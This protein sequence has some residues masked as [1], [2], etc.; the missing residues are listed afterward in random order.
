MKKGLVFA[1]LF[2]FLIQC[3]PLGVYASIDDV[4]KPTVSRN[5]DTQT[6]AEGA[7]N[8]HI[9]D[10]LR[11]IGA[12]KESDAVNAGKN[13]TREYA[14]AVLARAFSLSAGTG[15]KP[16]T[17]VDE[18]NV[19]IN[20][21]SALK[22][23]GAIYCVGREFEPKKEISAGEL[24]YMAIKLLGQEWTDTPEEALREAQEK[25]LF[26]GTDLPVRDG[27][28]I[29]QLYIFVCNAL[30]SPRTEYVP[31]SDGGWKTE[32]KESLLEDRNIV[33]SE[34]IITG[35]GV[36]TVYGNELRE[37]AIELDRKQFNTLKNAEYEDVGK[38]AVTFIDADDGV[39]ISYEQRN[40]EVYK[41]KEYGLEE[42]EQK[43]I[44]YSDE[45]GKTKK[46]TI[47]ENAKLIYNGTGMGTYADGYGIIADNMTLE[48]I[49]NNRDGD[50]DIVKVENPEYLI[51]E[52]VSEYSEIVSL[53]YG[54]GNINF[55]DGNNLIKLTKGGKDISFAEL[56]KRMV[57]KSLHS[58]NNAG[59]EIYII[60]VSDKKITG[61]VTEIE[62]DEDR[63]YYRVGKKQYVL[64]Q[65]YIEFLSSDSSEKKPSP[66][67]TLTFC[68]S[69]DGKI[70][71]SFAA[72]GEIYFGFLTNAFPDEENEEDIRVR[73]FEVHTDEAAIYKLADK[74]KFYDDS[75][76]I[77]GRKMKA[78]DIYPYLRNNGEKR[79]AVV[80]YNFN[81]ENEL[82]ELAF[83]KNLEGEK[84][85][86]CDYPL[87]KNYM[88]TG[89]NG[90]KTADG[91]LY[92]NVL[93]AKWYFGGNISVLY[94][95]SEPE[96]MSDNTKY[97]VGKISDY[98]TEHYF[99]NEKAYVY[100]ADKTYCGSL[101]VVEGGQA[102]GQT[103]KEECKAVMINRVY[104]GLSDDEPV[105]MVEVISPGGEPKTLCLS[106]DAEISK[107]KEI[108]DSQ[109]SGY[110]WGVDDDSLDKLKCGDI[111]QYETDS[112]GRM[113]VVR[114]LFKEDNRGEY[115]SQ[116][117]DNGKLR[118]GNSA[119]TGCVMVIYGKVAEY[120][121]AKSRFIIDVGTNGLTSYASCFMGGYGE[122]V[123]YTLYDS[124]KNKAM[125]TDA[126][127]VQAGDTVVVRKRFN[128]GL[129]MFIFR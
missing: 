61:T 117:Y 118:M 5:A 13:A 128:S 82:T 24:A 93:G 51:V 103:V 20:E 94:V 10:L 32:E 97:S 2:T 106:T 19:Y 123:C 49:D 48:V 105:T 115:R 31:S 35:A 99:I 28:S 111:I 77:Q 72:D 44:R 40:N 66:G 92:N 78:A 34:G 37:G 29:R 81:E 58:T 55:G 7:E 69:W 114:I 3:V 27:V 21:I 14:A 57:L 73:I 85:A 16:F 125:K 30:N 36:C 121:D 26:R 62:K 127:E 56:G 8:L 126:A 38:N 1:F 79:Y 9:T 15:E 18:D 129:D 11:Y 12:V 41:I 104:T 110:W 25:K 39:V 68:L 101:L 43:Y 23:A 119:Y 6:A 88:A 124:K 74:V 54:K 83:E 33:F 71:A 84:P 59:K 70:A 90:Y 113:C 80:G 120:N 122:K 65:Q 63:T 67:E 17:D 47:S 60:T 91:A 98:G 102:K 107:D 46:L 89:N 75:N 22:R 45:S 64:T 116:R 52:S 50:A 95:P 87:T 109:S 4:P 42:C 86:S 100:N 108:N 76:G 96:Q 53:M 112:D